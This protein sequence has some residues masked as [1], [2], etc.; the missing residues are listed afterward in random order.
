MT[1]RKLRTAFIGGGWVTCNR[2]IPAAA[3]LPDYEL[4]G[5]ISTEHNLGVLDRAALAQ[6]YGFKHFG[7][8]MQ[9]TWLND[10]DAVVIG[11]PPDTHHALVLEAMARGKHVLVEKPFA[12]TTV[13]ADDMQAAARAANKALGVIHNLQFAKSSAAALEKVKSGVIGDL[14]GVFGFQTSNHR[15]R[16]PRW[17]KELPLGLFTDESPHLI[18]MMQALLPNAD[19]MMTYVAPKIAPDDNTPRLVST[20]FLSENGAVNGT[21]NMTFVGAVSEWLLTILGS[22]RTLVVDFFRDIL[23]DL[24]DDGRH[25]SL[26]VVRTTVNVVGGHMAGYAVNGVGHLTKSLDYGNVEVFRRFAAH[27]LHGQPLRAISALD[28]ANVVAV[29]HRI[30]QARDGR[31]TID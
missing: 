24:P 5:M 7:A 21:L 18:Y 14:R 31:T 28:G 23:L 11:T 22:K 9:E 1:E 20:Q 26:D 29:M 13:Q 8:S 17:Y 25:E 2:H 15:R 10:V 6:K 30:N 27:V 3:R 19:Q 12:M 16:L 4:V